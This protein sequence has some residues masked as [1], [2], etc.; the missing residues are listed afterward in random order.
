MAAVQTRGNGT[1]TG[2]AKWRKRKV[3]P[4]FGWT[5]VSQQQR[6]G[7]TVTLWRC[8]KL[9]KD[10]HGNWRRCAYVCRKDRTHNSHTHKFTI[11]P[12]TDDGL[13]LH[14]R[15]ANDPNTKSFRDQVTSIVA[16]WGGEMSI[17]VRALCSECNRR[18]LIDI[19]NL[20]IDYK[21]KNRGQTF[22][23]EA[24]IPSFNEV[25]MTQRLVEAGESASNN[26]GKQLQKF[27]FVNIMIDAATVMNMKVVHTTLSNPFSSL[28]PLPFR[29][30]TK[31]ESEWRVQDYKSDIEKTLALLR[32]STQ[33]VPISVCHDR[34]SAQSEAV[35]QISM[36][37]SQCSEGN[38]QLLVDIPCLNHLLNN[39]FSAT[40]KHEK[41]RWM[42]RVVEDL[43][44][45]IREKAAVKIIGSRCPLPVPTRWLYICDTLSFIIRKMEKINKFLDERFA[46]L[47]PQFP[48]ARKDMTTEQMDTYR[49]EAMVPQMCLDLHALLAPAKF[50][51]LCFECEQSRLSDAIS[52]IQTITAAYKHIVESRMLQSDDS[53]EFLHEFL[54]QM[55]ARL[56]VYLPEETWAAWA[57]TREG[58]VQLREKIKQSGTLIPGD[59]N[60]Y[61]TPAFAYND[62]AESMKNQIDETFH[63][64]ADAQRCLSDLGRQCE[65][66]YDEYDLEGDSDGSD[67]QEDSD[68][69]CQLVP[70]TNEDEDASES[71]ES[72]IATEYPPWSESQG[73]TESFYDT[74]NSQDTR[75]S[76]V[77]K[78]LKRNR[79]TELCHMVQT[80]DVLYSAY[81]KAQQII[82]KY[83]TALYPGETAERARFLFDQWIYGWDRIPKHEFDSPNDF[84]MWNNLGKY[85]LSKSMTPV[86]LRL[87]SLATSESDVE[88]VI[89][90][91]RYIVHE[92][93]T[94]ISSKV[95]L[96]RLRL[97]AMRLTDREL[98]HT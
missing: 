24:M 56:E 91:H 98:D 43:A 51:S 85:E 82:V 40:I 47:Y 95:L 22:F 23:P 21:A 76:Q 29:T 96:A 34:L 26:I 3:D 2:M 63:L 27:R 70:Q 60:D 1:L 33:L 55:F 11:D 69:V 9:E 12:S 44:A 71:T 36:E 88:R 62:A 75:S 65:D 7:K 19:M 45:M 42:I 10:I 35:R 25:E 66:S 84:E 41:F 8:G 30:T 83:F 18:F 61:V 20:V 52:I 89:S 80:I 68:F 16:K 72:T 81:E 50:A 94:R 37:F 13:P 49:N 28:P 32:E 31:E 67:Q 86:A 64:I 15:A 4:P 6:N 39:A 93:M 97:H 74:Q 17:S 77:K 38:G 53:Y 58:R 14:L 87:I 46:R 48:R 54:S 90:V 73:S 59:A 5:Q 92:R 57:L 78:A 79:Q